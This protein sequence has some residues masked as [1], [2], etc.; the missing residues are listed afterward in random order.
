MQ[1]HVVVG[2]DVVESEPG[3][4]ERLELCANLRGELAAHGWHERVAHPCAHESVWHLAGIIAE[5]RQLDPW[6]HRA[7]SRHHQMQA[8]RQLRQTFGALDGVGG[9]RRADHQARGGEHAIA[10][11]SLDALVDG[12]GQA[13]VV[14]GEDDAVQGARIVACR[15]QAAFSRPRRNLKNSTPSRS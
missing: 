2:I 6:Q 5:I 12:A 3:R 13:E 7:T 11:R 1:M 4:A 9:G 14:T 8:Y 15:V 10:V